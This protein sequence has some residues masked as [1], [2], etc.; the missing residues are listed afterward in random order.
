MFQPEKS[1]S[2]SKLSVDIL[3]KSD[4][5]I[6]MANAKLTYA[7]MLSFNEQY[8]LSVEIFSEAYKIFSFLNCHF[9]MLVAITNEVLNRYKLGE[10]ES[11]I[12]ICNKTLLQISNFNEKNQFGSEILHLPLGMCYFELNKPHLAIENLIK[13]KNNIDQ[14]GLFH[15]H[16][17]VEIF[18]FKSYYILKDRKNMK[19]LID[20]TILKF[21]HM[22]YTPTD[23]LISFF[24]IFFYE[25]KDL[26]S[27]NSAVEKIE[28]EFQKSLFKS[29]F[30]IIDSLIMLKLKG[31][32]VS[33]NI[34]FLEKTLN[35]LKYTG[36]ISQIQKTLIQ[37]A[38]LYYFKKDYVNAKKYLKDSLKIYEEFKISGNFFVFL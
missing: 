20:E 25:E 37:L 10:F 35:H 19:K 4:K 2:Y 3:N 33:L 9:L 16:G 11:V 24:K 12:S 34:D 13:A 38:E 21:G 27:L 18:L 6:F 7:Q 36:F 14:S 22:N 28:L 23:F 30:I 5:T 26:S 8:R 31:Y 17:F 29:N 32:K 1:L 15:M